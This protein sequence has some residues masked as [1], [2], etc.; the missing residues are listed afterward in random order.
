[1]SSAASRHKTIRQARGIIGGKHKNIASAAAAAL[2]AAAAG[3]DAGGAAHARI[4][5]GNRRYRAASAPR[6]G[7][8]DCVLACR[9]L[10]WEDCQ[11]MAA[12]EKREEGGRTGDRKRANEE[13][14]RRT[15]AGGRAAR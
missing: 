15:D 1:M 5:G 14:R 13:E 6:L 9:L 10:A 3:I 11:R 4:G 8:I 2:S 12:K 7:S